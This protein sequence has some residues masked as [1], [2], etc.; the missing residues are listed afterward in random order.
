MLV[1][2]LDEEFSVLGGGGGAERPLVHDHFLPNPF[3]ATI[4][5]PTILHH[6]V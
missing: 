3:Q 4:H 1:R 2:I 5:D 6:M